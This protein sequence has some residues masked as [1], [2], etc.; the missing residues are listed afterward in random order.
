[1]IACAKLWCRAACFPV[2]QPGG[3]FTWPICKPLL[4]VVLSY[5]LEVSRAFVGE[6]GICLSSA[7]WWGK[8]TWVAGDQHALAKVGKDSSQILVL[9]ATNT[10]WDCGGCWLVGLERLYFESFMYIM[11]EKPVRSTYQTRHLSVLMN[12]WRTKQ[13]QKVFV[14]R[15]TICYD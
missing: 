13:I 12:H 9:G 8:K 2:R 5:F 7:W 15:A 3:R 4:L 6:M 1:M 10:P 11:D 14:A